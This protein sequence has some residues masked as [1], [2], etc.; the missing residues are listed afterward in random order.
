MRDCCS[1]H[2]KNCCNCI[3]GIV[4]AGGSDAPVEKPEPLIGIYD[5]IFRRVDRQQ[6][7]EQ[8]KY[9]IYI[10]I[11]Y[12]NCCYV[13]MSPS[14]R[15]IVGAECHVIKMYCH[16]QKRAYNNKCVKQSQSKTIIIMASS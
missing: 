3:L 1:K 6:C 15:R 13:V 8:F 9:G 7:G 14:E 5:A 11:I 4:C 10:F 2:N 12:I 16:C